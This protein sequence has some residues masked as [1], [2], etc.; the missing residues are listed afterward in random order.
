M[1]HRLYFVQFKFL[2]GL[3]LYLSLKWIMDGRR[4]ENWEMISIAAVNNVSQGR[5]GLGRIFH[6]YVLY[7]IITTE[8]RVHGLEQLTYKKSPAQIIASKN[9]TE[10][11]IGSTLLHLRP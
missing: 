1:K 6:C 5:K 11:T 9:G 8:V 4:L 10:Y 3:P 2:S 7:T